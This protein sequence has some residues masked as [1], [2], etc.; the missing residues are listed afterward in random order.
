MKNFD[1]LPLYDK[2]LHK[3]YAY[4]NT[5]WK[6]KWKEGIEQEWLNNFQDSDKDL[7]SKCQKPL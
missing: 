2:L 7:E 4:C 1:A 5:I 6:D 3:I